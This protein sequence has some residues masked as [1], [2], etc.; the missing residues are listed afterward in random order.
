MFCN[1]EKA[2]KLQNLLF[3]Y[4]GSSMMVPCLTALAS[5]HGSESQK[6]TLLGIWR[7]LGALARAVGPVVTSVGKY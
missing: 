4:V 6:G 1:C 5:C 2:R 3:F 7:S